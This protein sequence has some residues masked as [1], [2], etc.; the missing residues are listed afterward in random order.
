MRTLQDRP[1]SRLGRTLALVA[2]GVMVL[3]GCSDDGPGAADAGE[4]SPASTPSTSSR[5]K[6]EQ[7]VTRALLTAAQVGHDVR[8]QDD[9]SGVRAPTNDVCGKSWATN[10]QRVAR[11][12][13]FFWKD[14]KAVDL[15]VSHEVVV[16]RKGA[17]PG[18]LEEIEA[19][20]ADCDGW[21]HRQGEIKDPRLT[22]PPATAPDGA[23]AWAATDERQGTEF[24]YLAVYQ[25]EGD[26][27]SA[28]YVWAAG[29]RSAAEIADELTP[30]V[31]ARL[32]RT[33]N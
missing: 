8:V 11:R 10:T 26:V 21:R 5:P 29:T 20:V 22:D 32:E 13:L 12:Q 19:A 16:Y 7:A 17:A 14:A 3:T 33:G 6:P 23:V 30:K 18:V 15:V 27:L 25:V 1:R 24:S 31:T 4:R 2:T 28:L 9:S